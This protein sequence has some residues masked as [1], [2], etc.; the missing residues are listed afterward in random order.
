MA[1][2]LQLPN[3]AISPPPAATHSPT[4]PRPCH[5]MRAFLLPQ[6]EKKPYYHVFKLAGFV[7]FDGDF[8][9]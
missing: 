3:A 5:A 7:G 4:L 1:L 2:A 9:G 6:I 8:K